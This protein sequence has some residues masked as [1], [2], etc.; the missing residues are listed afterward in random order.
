M[1]KNFTLQDIRHVMDI[2]LFYKKKEENLCVFHQ[3]YYLF[4]MAVNL[5][6]WL[7]GCLL[8]LLSYLKLI[9]ALLSFTSELTLIILTTFILLRTSNLTFFILFPLPTIIESCVPVNFKICRLLKSY[10][11]Y[12]YFLYHVTFDVQTQLCFVQLKRC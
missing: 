12:H 3:Y 1:L 4:L 7:W 9:L 2:F 5:W 10:Y 6:N 11:A 8:L